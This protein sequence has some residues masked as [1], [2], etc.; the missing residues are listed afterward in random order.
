MNRIAV[1]GLGLAVASIMA[2]GGDFGGAVK[3]ISER[4]EFPA[5]GLLHLE[6]AVDGGRVVVIGRDGA[7]EVTVV[8]LQPAGEEMQGQLVAIQGDDTLQIAGQWDG[9]DRGVE[10]IVPSNLLLQVAAS[11]GNIDVVGMAVGA[12]VATQKGNIHV[13]T[14]LSADCSDEDGRKLQVA[15]EDGDIVVEIPATLNATVKAATDDGS[16]DVVDLP[17][18][19]GVTHPQAVQGDLGNG[20]DVTVEVATKKGNITLTALQ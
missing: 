18:T 15:S 1:L 11:E 8:P 16:I 13:S 14:S 3:F 12:Q 9:A 19:N 6:L 17:L 7:T 5:A 2:C 4:T 10:L 20:D